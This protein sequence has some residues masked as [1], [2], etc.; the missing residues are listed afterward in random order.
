LDRIKQMATN[1]RVSFKA[2]EKPDDF[3]SELNALPDNSV[4]R[5]WYIGHASDNGLMLKLVHTESC[6]PAAEP[7]DK[8][9]VA[10]IAKHAGTVSKKMKTKGKP[11][12]F[13]GCYT[14]SFAEQWTKVFG[15]AAEG[16]TKK[17]DFSVTDRDSKIPEV[18][19]RLQQSN[20]DTGWKQFTP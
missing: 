9:Y 18:M 6:A 5:L 17:I 15:T 11:S 3:W 10:D 2:L 7:K 19:P 8:I 12:E 16:A 20:P 1:L 4:S 14:Q 13:F